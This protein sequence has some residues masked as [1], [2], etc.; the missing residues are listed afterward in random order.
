M[1]C[2]V[3]LSLSLS[4]ALSFFHAHTHTSVLGLTPSGERGGEQTGG[5]WGEDR[6]SVSEDTND[7]QRNRQISRLSSSH[8][9]AAAEGVNTVLKSPEPRQQEPHGAAEH[10]FFP[11]FQFK[12]R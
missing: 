7:E 10:L 9:L 11:S 5:G 1:A 8:T 2:P 4:L 3:S 6:L 12:Q